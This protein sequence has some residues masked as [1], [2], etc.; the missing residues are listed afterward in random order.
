M[1]YC[2]AFMPSRQSLKQTPSQQQRLA[3]LCQAT[4]GGR[5]WGSALVLAGV[6]LGGAVSRTGA[7]TPP[8]APPPSTPSPATPV[9]TNPTTRPGASTVVTPVA[10]NETL[11]GLPIARVEVLGNT[12]TDAKMILDQVRSQAGQNYSHAAVDQDVRTIAALE[13]FITVR[14]EIVPTTEAR[15]V[16][17]FVVQ[18]RAVVTGVEIVGNHKKNDEKIRE[19]TSVHPGMGVDPFVISTDIKAIEEL[20][21][22]DGYNFAKVE[23]DKKALEEQGIVRYRIEEGPRGRIYHVRFDGNEHMKSYFLKW[24]IQTKS[25]IWIFRKGV[26]DEDKLEADLA[27]LREVYTGKGY[28]DCRV[29]RSVEY[30]PDKTKIT[31]RFAINEG[32]RYKVGKIA[33]TGNTVFSDA[34]LRSDIPLNHDDWAER[35]KVDSAQ[36]HIEDRYGH[37]G[38]INRVVDLKSTYTDQPGVVDLQFS[39]A[40]GKSYSVRRVIVRGNPNIQDRVIRRQIRVYPDQTYDTVLIRKSTERLKAT[41]LFS[42]VKISPI[43][44]DPDSRD[45]LVEAQE[46]Q[47]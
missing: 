25:Y 1:A 47:T 12:R 16:V 40:E 4:R 32:P 39:V 29:S 33:I 37:E 2:E 6:L 7:Q 31:V 46:G 38:Y 42:D 43:G 41:R 24:K 28:L 20:Y 10:V 26:L 22:K 19:V 45:V 18:E 11:E 21:R 14:A 13:R 23:V 30:N 27:T 5:N 15:V 8:V 17:R 36:K 44:D 35:T 9:P 3:A 34:D